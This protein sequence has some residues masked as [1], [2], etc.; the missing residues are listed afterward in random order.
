MA[1]SGSSTG[2]VERLKMKLHPKYPFQRVEQRAVAVDAKSKDERTETAQK[3]TNISI[4]TFTL[5]GV[6]DSD[7]VQTFTVAFTKAVSKSK[8]YA[9]LDRMFGVAWSPKTTNE[10]V[11]LSKPMTLKAVR[12][13]VK[14]A[15]ENSL[16][17]D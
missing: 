12:D 2:S 7:T 6:K 17:V 9:E 5:F 14:T 1:Y 11:H 16:K 3:M 4:G 15:Y 13:A 10:L 8:L